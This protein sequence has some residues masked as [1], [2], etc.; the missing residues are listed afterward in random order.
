MQMKLTQQPA[1][2][3]PMQRRLFMFMPFMFLMFSFQVA[4]GLTLYWVVSNL[5]SIVQQRFTV[6]WGSLPYLG[7]PAPPAAPNG[8]SS[9]A[10]T[11][12][13]RG[14]SPTPVRRRS[15]SSRRRKGK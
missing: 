7:T 14:P 11:P 4:A 6:G 12:P 10:V 3:D 2:V 8:S 5:Y 1:T 13:S 9:Q 15:S